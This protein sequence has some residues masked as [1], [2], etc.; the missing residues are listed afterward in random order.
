MEKFQNSGKL[1]EAFEKTWK[2]SQ[3]DIVSL[4]LSKG[5]PS[6]NIKILI[7]LYCFGF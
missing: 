5:I 1:E 7:T 2:F 3:N 4:E 6:H